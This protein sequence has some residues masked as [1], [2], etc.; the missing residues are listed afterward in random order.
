MLR[1]ELIGPYLLVGGGLLAGLFVG[2]FVVDAEPAIIGWLFG[3]GAGITLGAFLAAITSNEPLVGRG[4]FPAP[5]PR[6]PHSLD[7]HSLDGEAALDETD[8]AAGNED[9]AAQ[10]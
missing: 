9:E 5:P 1:R 7:G 2:V 10:P 4:A 6:Q 3:A 8:E